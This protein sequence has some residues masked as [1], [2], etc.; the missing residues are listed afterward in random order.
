MPG[1]PLQS[2]PVLLSTAITAAAWAKGGAPNGAVVVAGQQVSP[3]GHAD[4]PWK[5]T[6]GTG[7]AFSLILRPELP[8][9]REGWLYIVATAALAAA[10]G[11][12]A[13]IHW[14][15]E[16]HRGEALTAAV[17]MQVRLGPAKIQWAV[18]NMWLA[19]AE[20]PRG[21]VLAALL[22]GFE[23]RQ[24]RD[25]GP[26]LEEYAR[27][28]TTIGRRVSA[29]LLGGTGP[30]MQGRALGAAEDGALVLETDTGKRAP[31]RPQDVRGVDDAE[32]PPAGGLS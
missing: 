17:G 7:L 6:P 27:A 2:Y 3:R 4:R 26:L 31:V 5:L 12:D 10:C 1:R 30:R 29:R 32:T 18:V 28:S 19:E 20:P 22:Q 8:P 25:T 11:E 14:P 16:V 15:D 9:Q 13:R 23:E 21:R 24:A